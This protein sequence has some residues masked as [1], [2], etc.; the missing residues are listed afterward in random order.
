MGLSPGF[1]SSRVVTPVERT[2]FPSMYTAIPG[3][4]SEGLF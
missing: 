2:P 3:R 4:V 1:H